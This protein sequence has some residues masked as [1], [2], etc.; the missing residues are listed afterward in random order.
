MQAL[1]RAFVLGHPSTV[2]GGRL[3]SGQGSS[4]GVSG[5]LDTFGWG[6]ED[7]SELRWLAAAPSLAPRYLSKTLHR[8]LPSP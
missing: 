7:T 2:P 4:R 3:L 8:G 6:V 5:L 1:L